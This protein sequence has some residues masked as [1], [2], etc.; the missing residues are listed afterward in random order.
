MTTKWLKTSKHV[1]AVI[2]AEHREQL[3]A[4]GSY[5]NPDGDSPIG[6]GYPEM[7]THWGLKGSDASLLK[8]I[9]KEE[10]KGK[11]EHFYW[12]AIVENDD[13]T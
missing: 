8:H 10:E 11:R 5:S 2:F 13:V 3:E 7:E 9:W 12:I 1:F 4:F 6:H